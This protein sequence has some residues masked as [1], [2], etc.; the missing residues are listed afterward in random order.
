MRPLFRGG[1]DVDG[2]SEGKLP[3]RVG[4]T[5]GAN[6]ESFEGIAEG[7][8]EGELLGV[9]GKVLRLG[10]IEILG[11]AEGESL[12]LSDGF[13]ECKEDGT[14]EEVFEGIVE[15]ISEG[16]SLAFSDVF[17]VGVLEGMSEGESIGWSEDLIDGISVVVLEGI[18]EG[19]S[20][21]LS[22]ELIDGFNVGVLEGM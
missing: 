2:K 19:E 11:N 16:E 17:G 13:N 8:S 21:G 3:L 5:F 1:T 10:T 14:A 22:E 12:A 4:T 9:D 7:I 20:I 18:S 6:E 15:G